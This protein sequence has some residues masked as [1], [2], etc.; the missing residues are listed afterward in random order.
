MNPQ[1]PIYIP[2]KGRAESRL[3]VKMLIALGIKDWHICVEPQ[4][5]REYRRVIAKEH[6]LKLPFSNLGQGSIPARNF[7]WEHSIE[8]GFKKHWILDDNIRYL[9]VLNRNRKV[10]VGS[11]TI[12][13]A[14]EDFTDRFENVKLSGFQ[15]RYFCEERCGRIPPYYL[16][17]RVYSMILIDNSLD[18]RWRGKYNEDTDLCL[19][20]MKQGW[21]TV[22]FNTFMCDKVSTQL[23]GGGNTDNVYI[24]GDNRMGFAQALVDQH[25]D[26]V[27]IME[28]YGRWHHL[29][30]YAPFKK[31]HLQYKDGID[32]PNVVNNYGLVLKR[33]TDEWIK[34]HGEEL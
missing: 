5:Y 29:V 13:K 9:R 15:Y 28:R 32:P 1:Y 30:N 12:M 6:I 26:V 17:T 16:N 2:S 4:E 3:T 25:P 22:L 21:C 19:R 18:I 24:D 34:E 14:A 20:A 11:G 7:I 33:K 27:S 23:M 8:R 31:N 10:I